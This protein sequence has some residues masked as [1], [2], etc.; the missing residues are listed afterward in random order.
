MIV[1]LSVSRRWSHAGSA[2]VKLPDQ[3]R[4]ESATIPKRLYHAVSIDEN[5]KMKDLNNYPK[6]N[7]DYKDDAGIARMSSATMV[8][9]RSFLDTFPSRPMEA[10]A[11][12]NIQQG[13]I[14]GVKSGLQGWDS[15][16]LD[17]PIGEGGPPTKRKLCILSMDGGGIRGL[18]AARTLTRLENLIQVFIHFHPLSRQIFALSELRA[19]KIV[20]FWAVMYLCG[21]EKLGC[22]EVHLSDYFDLF[23]GTSTGAILATML[24]VPDEKGHPQF[25]AKGCCEFYSKNGEYIFRPRWYDPFH[26]SVRQFYR[27]KYSPRR[28]EDLLKQHTIMKNGKVLTLVDALKP[29][30]ITSFDISRATPFF[31]VRQAAANDPSRNFTWGFFSLIS[32]PFAIHFQS[33]I[34][35]LYCKISSLLTEHISNNYT[36]YNSFLFTLTIFVGFQFMGNLSCNGC[37]THVLPACICDFCWWQVFGYYDWWRRYSK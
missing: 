15:D 36:L 10:D 26:G 32:L 9:I 28:F 33:R 21:Q 6:K 12:A 29:L 17:L 25:S 3:M 30:L 23:T 22:E 34:G 37:S 11:G 2:N 20:W 18:I 31:F 13:P 35:I 16:L 8:G 1:L 24:V 5:Q 19:F 27:P 14:G 7:L 4:R